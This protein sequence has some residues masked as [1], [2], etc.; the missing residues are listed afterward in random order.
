MTAHAQDSCGAEMHH[1]AR[2][3]AHTHTHTHTHVAKNTVNE[4]FSQPVESI[5][6]QQPVIRWGD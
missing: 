6:E 2:A 3:R 1:S 4:Y 5:I